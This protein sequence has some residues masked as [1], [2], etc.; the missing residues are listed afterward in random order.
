MSSGLKGHSCVAM[1]TLFLP[2]T[3]S[4]SRILTAKN[5]QA[6]SQA[7]QTGT[8]RKKPSHKRLLAEPL[9]SHH[10]AKPSR[11]KQKQ[12]HKRPRNI[13]SD[14]DLVGTHL[15]LLL[16]CASVHP[17]AKDRSRDR[18]QMLQAPILTR[19]Q[20]RLAEKRWL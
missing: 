14:K 19:T 18:P 15:V 2:T 7:A 5:S 11:T 16:C 12:S 1:K 9:G 3:S 17:K 10:H 20:S 6:Q 4:S 8:H 13:S